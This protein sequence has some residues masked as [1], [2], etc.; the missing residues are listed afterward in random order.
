MRRRVRA[1]R[2]DSIVLPHKDRKRT[3]RAAG[4]VVQF[5]E[6]ECLWSNEVS[7]QRPNFRGFADHVYAV[8]VNPGHPT[9]NRQTVPL[10]P[11]DVR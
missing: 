8:P 10:R 3:I 4:V 2:Y 9:R 6:I 11:L 5:A 1:H 7:P